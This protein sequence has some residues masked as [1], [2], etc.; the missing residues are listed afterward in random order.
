MSSFIEKYSKFV[1]ASDEERGKEYA[2][3]IEKTIFK[4]C[5]PDEWDCLKWGFV[6]GIQAERTEIFNMIDEM[7]L[8]LDH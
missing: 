7:E 2:D 3:R 6:A 4:K 1:K 5:T 8:E